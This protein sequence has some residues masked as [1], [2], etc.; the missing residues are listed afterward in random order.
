MKKNKFD[1]RKVLKAGIFLMAMILVFSSC[2]K[3]SSTDTAVISAPLFSIGTSV[4]PGNISGSIKGTMKSDSVYY[5]TGDVIINA[6]DTLLVQPGVKIYF[7]GNYNFWIHGNLVSLGTKAKP[8]YFTVQ[9]LSKSDVVGQ[10]PTTDNAYVGTW[11]GLECDTT[12]K[13]LILKWTHIEFGGGKIGTSQVFG[14]SNNSTAWMISF[15]NPNGIFDLEDSWIYGGVDDPIRIQGGKI[16]I[17][18]NTS[19]KG[20]YTG[21]EGIAN[22]KSGTQ[23]NVAY[24]LII[25]PSTN[26]VKPSNKGGKSQTNIVTYNNTI[27]NGGYRRFLYGGA[28][29]SL[30]RGGS[31]NY[32]EGSEGLVYNNLLVDCKFG[33]R[34]VGTGN[35]LGNA[36]VI[37]DTAHLSYGYNW[38]YADSTVMANQFYPTSFLTKPMSTDVPAPTYLLPT[39]TLGASYSG[40]ANVGLNDPQ[41]V[42][43]TLP[44]AY[45][46]TV[47]AK[48]S[49][50]SFATGYDFHLKSTSP[51]IGKAYTAFAPLSV[52]PVDAN[53]G[54]TEITLP[55]ADFGAYQA[56]GAGNKH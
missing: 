1:I 29:G 7:K 36:L 18:R 34:V 49:T 9:G 37:A 33:L 27:V 50:I 52:V 43:Y 56:N 30:G 19:E 17:M 21:G 12:T 54:A 31:I 20:G 3:N 55:G 48:L 46:T 25:G 22:I 47:D 42:N 40:S 39:Y 44:V 45:S 15:A 32:E 6:G 24:N 5:V 11:G 2:Q 10:D 23:G 13:F 14:V 35:Y 4:A 8:V 16:N 38:N 51:C 26:G 28:G 53:F 41:F